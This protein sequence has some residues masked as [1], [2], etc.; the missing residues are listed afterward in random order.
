[1]SVDDRKSDDIDAALRLAGATAPTDGADVLPDVV[2]R[3]RAGALD[4]DQVEAVE[5]QLAADPA[6]RAYAAGLSVTPDPALV[7][8]AVDQMPSPAVT[9]PSTGRRLWLPTLALAAGLVLAVG[10]WRAGTPSQPSYAPATLE[11]LSPDGQGGTYRIRGDSAPLVAG[12]TW[13]LRV[14]PNADEGRRQ[15]YLRVFV[16]GPKG[17]LKALT[18]AT[19]PGADG[20]FEVRMAATN[21]LAVDTDPVVLHIAI[22]AE[23][24]ALEGLEGL[25]QTA[26]SKEAGGIWQRREVR[27]TGAAR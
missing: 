8:W 9:G 7:D 5:A 24:D 23:P 25:D 1:M 22:N 16:E 14:A 17:G 20:Q 6:G 18:E 2:E 4:A 19:T 15:G 21:I 26:A 13:I 10:L 12:Q 11:I 27:R 3:W